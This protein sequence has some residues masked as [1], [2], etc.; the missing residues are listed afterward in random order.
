MSPSLR[1]PAARPKAQPIGAIIPAVLGQAQRHHGALLAIQRGWG[2]FVGKTLAAHTK[3]V[4][5]RRGRLIVHAARP[6]DSFMLSYRRVRL[7]ERLQTAAKGRVEE[8]VI[9]PGDLGEKALTPRR[10]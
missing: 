4:S 7:L 1:E 2:R 6:G 8:I 5:L 9:R 3:P 10:K